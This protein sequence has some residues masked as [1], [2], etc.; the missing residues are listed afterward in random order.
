V[1]GAIA[2]RIANIVVPITSTPTLTPIDASRNVHPRA[3]GA[4]GAA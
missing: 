4:G 1:A 3:G 2:D